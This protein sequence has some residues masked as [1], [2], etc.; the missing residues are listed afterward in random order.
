MLVAPDTSIRSLKSQVAAEHI[1]AFPDHGPVTVNSLQVRRRDTLFHLSESMTVMSAFTRVKGG[2]FLHA[3]ITEARVGM[4]CCQGTPEIDGRKTSG[5][6]AGMHVERHARELLAATPHVANDGLTHGLGGGDATAELNNVHARDAVLYNVL[7]PPSSSLLD[8]KTKNEASLASDVDIDKSSKQTNVCHVVEADA[9]DYFLHGDRDHDVDG[10]ANKQIKMKEEMLGQVHVDDIS[11]GKERKKAKKRKITDSAH[12]SATDARISN[13]SC[14]MDTNKSIR[15]P[16]ETNPT[17]GEL[18]NVSLG[19]EVIDNIPED[20]LQIENLSI[21][22][23]KKKKKK[24]LSAPSEAVSGQEAAKLPTVTVGLTKSGADA[25][26]VDMISGDGSTA[27]SSVLLSSLEPN[28]ES[29]GGK[30]VQFVNNVQASTDLTSE[31]ENLGHMHNGDRN[32]SIRD[33]INSAAE[34][35]VI[36][37]RIAEASNGACDGAE[38]HEETKQHK[39]NGSSHDADVAETSNMK[40]GGK[41]IDALEERPTN[42]NISRE[43]KRKKVKKVNIVDMASIDIGGDQQILGHTEDAGKTDKVYT[44]REILHGLS[45]GPVSD[46]VQQGDSNVIGNQNDAKQATQGSVGAIVSDSKFGE[47]LDK[48]AA[49]MIN[50]VLA[51]LKSRDSLSKELSEDLV[52]GQIHLDGNPNALEFPASTGNKADDHAALP[53]KYPDAIHSDTPARSCSHKKPK[54]KQSKVLPTMINSSQHSCGMPQE[55]AD[56]KLKESDT[57]RCPGKASDLKDIFTGD[58]V[59]QADDKTKSTKRQSKKVKKV[60]TGNGKTTQSLDEQVNHQVARED[61]EG[62]NAAIQADLV[63]AGS[64][65][66]T[67]MGTVT[68]VQHKGK[69]TFETQA[70][71]MQE[72]SHFANAAQDSHDENAIGITG[73]HDN[74]NSSGHPT[75]SPAVQEDAATLKSSSPS[76][77]KKRKK[78]LKTGLQSQNSAMEHDSNSD[79][80]H[81]N[82]KKGLVSA[83]NSAQPNHCITAHTESDKINFLDHFSL[84]EMNDRL[85]SA[86][87]IQNNEAEI[88]EAKNTKNTCS[89]EPNDLL[90]SLPPAEKT[91]LTDHFGTIEV[92]VPSTKAE[93]MNSGKEKR[94]RKRKP[95]SEGPATDKENLD[96]DH[97]CTDQAGDN[98]M[99]EIEAEKQKPWIQKRSSGPM[100]EMDDSPKPWMMH[101]ESKELRKSASQEK[102]HNLVKSFAMSPAASSDSTEATPQIAKR[103]RRAVRKV[104]KQRY[105]EAN[106]KFKEESRKVGSGAL[107]NDAISEEPNDVKDIKGEKAALGTSLDNSS[108]SVNSGALLCLI[109]IMSAS[110]YFIYGLAYDESDV[111]DDDEAL[112][113]SQKSLRDLDIGSILRGSRSYKKAKQKEAELLDDDTEVPDSQPTD[114]LFWG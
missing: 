87:N 113:L 102:P 103:S 7:A 48:A 22:G 5:G 53:L 49:N 12:T 78:P 50:E 37:E 85:I 24:R 33:A 112:S 17:H 26:E 3:K 38:E 94:K 31:Q 27:R 6:H 15:A 81:C 108:A 45:V 83:K 58:Y 77:R 111:P 66:N 100:D 19:K 18:S 88:M 63:R 25:Y 101:N 57:L 84:G 46:N 69:R 4:H 14:T 8:T 59:V 98:W 110:L 64:V 54:G 72:T 35:P 97:R 51:D 11:Q 109:K 68:K 79:L 10:N 96:A 80:L 70:S 1:A 90:E 71:K 36:G 105:E 92:V 107:F 28:D 47:N 40:K 39:Y 76:A 20:S 2:C 93:N 13:E 86:E 75:E 60:P 21:V 95:N 56:T 91:S 43:K 52:T 23:K 104:S 34:V 89:T 61:I 82:A 32:P 30:Q 114:G 16:L 29:Q 9:M 73:T 65:I 67:P 62:G 74:K 44:E 55:D 106:V 42:D 99:R 41:S